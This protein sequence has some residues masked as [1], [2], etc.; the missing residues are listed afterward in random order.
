MS[1]GQDPKEIRYNLRRLISIDIRFRFL[2]I[3]SLANRTSQ[4]R[5]L[6]LL[7]YLIQMRIDLIFL[8]QHLDENDL[9]RFELLV[10]QINNSYII[11]NF[12]DS[13]E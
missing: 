5:I 7:I 8:Y 4:V 12:A 3:Q 13:F 2:V 1:N 10:V 6:T 11:L 9:T